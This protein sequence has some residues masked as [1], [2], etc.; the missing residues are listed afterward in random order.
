MTFYIL[1]CV[2]PP[3]CSAQI[4]QEKSPAVSLQGEVTPFSQLPDIATAGNDKV[5]QS[6]LEQL[7]TIAGIKTSMLRHFPMIVKR[8]RMQHSKLLMI[9]FSLVT[10]MTMESQW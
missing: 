6:S 7:N 9:I 3:I 4:P 10:K 8:V 2:G 1:F 5:T